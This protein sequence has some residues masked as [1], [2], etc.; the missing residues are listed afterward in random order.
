MITRINE[1]L[2][3]NYFNEMKEV[4]LAE[5]VGLCIFKGI[6]NRCLESLFFC[7]ESLGIFPSPVL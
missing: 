2:Q 5:F 6:E 3:G 4:I 1:F 7:K